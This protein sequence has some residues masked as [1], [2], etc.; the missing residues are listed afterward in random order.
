MCKQQTYPFTT[1][2]C[3]PVVPIAWRP[4]ILSWQRK[5]LPSS[6]AKWQPSLWFESL[7]CN[8]QIKQTTLLHSGRDIKTHESFSKWAPYFFSFF[9]IFFLWWVELSSW[10][11]QNRWNPGRRAYPVLSVTCCESH[12]ISELLP[13]GWVVKVIG[14]LHFFPPLLAL[15]VLLE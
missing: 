9:V 15:F 7:K 11:S 14:V 12:S 1:A 13:L 2:V 10:S 6:G 8:A 4:N 5:W 3:Q